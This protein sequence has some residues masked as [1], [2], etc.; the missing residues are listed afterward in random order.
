MTFGWCSVHY[1]TSVKLQKFVVIE[2][3]E[4]VFNCQS[5]SLSRQKE[6]YSWGRAGDIIYKIPER[7][8]STTTPM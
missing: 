6:K 7:P 8:N 5:L 1:Y 4:I 2:L 3:T